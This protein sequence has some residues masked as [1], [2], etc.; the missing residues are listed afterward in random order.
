MTMTPKKKEKILETKKDD[1]DNFI[2]KRRYEKIKGNIFLNFEGDIS[3]LFCC[4]LCNDKET[5]MNEYFQK[6]INEGQED[7]GYK[8]IELKDLDSIGLSQQS[9]NQDHVLNTNP[10]VTI[11]QN[12]NQLSTG[13][14]E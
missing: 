7:L 8:Q 2:I 14:E 6:L 11:P 10:E 4:N 12:N 13:S 5:N 1:L 3:L 9:D